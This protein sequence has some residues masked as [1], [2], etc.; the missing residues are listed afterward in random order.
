MNATTRRLTRP[1][2]TVKPADSGHWTDDAECRT[3]DDPDLW[4]AAGD[5][6]ASRAQVREAKDICNTRCAVREQCLQ[7]AVD[8]RQ[9]QGVWG[10]LS[11]RERR[12]LHGRKPRYEKPGGMTALD[13]IFA[14]QLPR[15]R[16][17]EMSGL[18]DFEIARELQT[19][20]QTI[21]NLRKRIAEQGQENLEVAA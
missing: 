4:H 5:G 2:A 10:G 8:N 20:V 18:E 11:E 13:Y 7:W 1:A 19:N 17:L 12:R 16:E 3:H 15:F 21:N 9:D 14:K 6:A